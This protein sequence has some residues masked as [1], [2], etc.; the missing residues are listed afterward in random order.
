MTMLNMR[1]ACWILKATNTLRM[2]NT[3]CFS[4]ATVV[5]RMRLNVTQY[6]LRTLP[7]LYIA[8]DGARVDVMLV[9]IIHGRALSVPEC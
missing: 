1:I 4:T 2:C 8:G 3:Y 5:T 7:V 9:D 6:I